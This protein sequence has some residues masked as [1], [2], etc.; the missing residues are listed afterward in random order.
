MLIP[1]CLGK[2]LVGSLSCNA[3]HGYLSCFSILLSFGH[4]VLIHLS[5]G[6]IPY[7]FIQCL[8]LHLLFIYLCVCSVSDTCGLCMCVCV[9]ECVYVC[10]NVCVY[11]CVC[12]RVYI[13][14][15]V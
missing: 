8:S 5:P 1:G 7:Y 12:E 10:M 4:W 2:Y 9:C 14:V 3:I 13:S 15:C 11:A 6:G